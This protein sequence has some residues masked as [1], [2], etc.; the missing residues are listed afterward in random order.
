M[1]KERHITAGLP[2]DAPA[3]GG[4]TQTPR[5]TRFTVTRA[6]ELGM[7][8]GVRDA[9]ALTHSISNPVNVTV[10]GQLVHNHQVTKT[11]ADQGFTLTDEAARPAT[12]QITTPSVLITAHGVSDAQRQSFIQAG[13]TIVDTTCPLVKKA[14]TAAL[15]LAHEDRHVL[16]IGKPGHVEVLGLTG[17]MPS[18]DVIPSPGDVKTYPYDRLGIIAQTTITDETY[19]AVVAEVKAKNPAADIRAIRTVCQ[20]TR[21]RQLALHDLLTTVDALIVVGG[22]NSNN[23]KM[24]LKTAH[25]HAKPALLVSKSQDLHPHAVLALLSATKPLPKLGLTAGTS[26]LDQTVDQVEQKLHQIAAGSD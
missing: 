3:A 13:L 25:H 4:S 8:F 5:Q 16:V 14:H 26:T 18:F 21:D 6:R 15:T 12:S 2:V 9:L 11:L 7:C 1:V 22:E 24:L 17:D 19:D 23:S 10:F 20:P